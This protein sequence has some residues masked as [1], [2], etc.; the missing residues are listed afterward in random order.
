LERISITSTP[1]GDLKLPTYD[2]LVGCGIVMLSEDGSFMGRQLSMGW[3]EGFLYYPTQICVNEKG[4]VFIA[5][6]GNNRVQIFAVI[7]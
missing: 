7:Q 6:R 3:T 1:S 2:Q 5:D 4:E